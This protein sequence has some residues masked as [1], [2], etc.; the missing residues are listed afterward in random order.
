MKAAVRLQADKPMMVYEQL[1]DNS[2]DSIQ[3]VMQLLSWINL[4]STWY[5]KH[6]DCN[7]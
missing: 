2:L 5:N 6:K 4:R 1:D 3:N 7:A